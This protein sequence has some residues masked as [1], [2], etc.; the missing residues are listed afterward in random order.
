[1]QTEMIRSVLL[2]VGSDP[3]SYAY[4]SAHEVPD[5]DRQHEAQNCGE[6]HF[7]DYLSS[8]RPADFR[9]VSQF[10]RIP[11]W[12]SL[13]RAGTSW[14]NRPITTNIGRLNS[15]RPDPWSLL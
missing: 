1:M 12:I 5:H 6:L 7:Q 8:D 10:G 9:E 4:S 15:S 13:W 11:R 2:A 3:I 14:S